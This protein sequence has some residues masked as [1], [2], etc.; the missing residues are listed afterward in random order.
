MAQDEAFLINENNLNL[1]KV[2]CCVNDFDSSLRLTSLGYVCN[3][4]KFEYSTITGQNLKIA[5]SGNS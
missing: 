2:L 5:K 1:Y 3:P 4:E